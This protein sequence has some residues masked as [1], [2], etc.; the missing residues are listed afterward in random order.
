MAHKW[1]EWQSFTGHDYMKG[2]SEKAQFLRNLKEFMKDGIE[3]RY[4]EAYGHGFREAKWAVERYGLRYTL[5]H[6]ARKGK[7]PE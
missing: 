7:L 1:L 6:I 4:S 2:T 3:R 5:K